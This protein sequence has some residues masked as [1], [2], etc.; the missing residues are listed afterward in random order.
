MDHPSC[1]SLMIF[2]L[3]SGTFQY[4]TCGLM[5]RLPE[6]SPHN[7][8]I[9]QY[10]S[11][12]LPNHL[13]LSDP[14]LFDPF[15]S[16]SYHIISHH[17]MSYHIISCPILSYLI[18][19]VPYLIL[20]CPVLSHLTWSYLILSYPFY[21]I[22]PYLLLSGFIPP[23]PILSYRILSIESHRSYLPYLQYLI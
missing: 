5:I 13:I 12:H 7:L 8:H 23:Y 20:L 11:T 17:F 4:R 15:L 22:L 9:S 10:L 21:I 2:P 3:K 1:K 18:S 16:Y 14:F 19:L 6:I